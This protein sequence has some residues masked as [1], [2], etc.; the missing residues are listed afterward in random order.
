MVRSFATSGQWFKPYALGDH[1]GF[2]ES[3]P[4]TQG[5]VTGVN[6]GEIS[7]SPPLIKLAGDAL[8]LDLATALFSTDSATTT[9]ISLLLH[10]TALFSAAAKCTT[11]IWFGLL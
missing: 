6:H 8:Q 11:A 9:L 5:N 4:Q 1:D 3:E 7:P 10:C 2:K